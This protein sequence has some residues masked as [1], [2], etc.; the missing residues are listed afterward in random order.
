M[1]LHSDKLDLNRLYTNDI[2]A[3]AH[4]YGIEAA[5]RVL[6]KVTIECSFKLIATLD[7]S[8]KFNTPQVQY[9]LSLQV[10]LLTSQPAVKGHFSFKSL[11]PAK[12]D[13]HPNKV[14]SFLRIGPSSTQLPLDQHPGRPC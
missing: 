10:T 14:S 4:V 3:M 11:S 2:H 5:C 6:I 9:N 13:F 1:Y 8:T 7:Q 12:I